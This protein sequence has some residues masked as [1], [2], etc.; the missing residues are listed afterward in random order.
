MTGD[1][2]HLLVLVLWLAVLG[3]L[4]ARAWRGQ[5]PVAGLAIA[6]WFQLWLIHWIGGAVYVLSNYSSQDRTVALIGFTVTG[7]AVAGLL[8]GNVLL[9][10]FLFRSQPAGQQSFR[11]IDSSGPGFMYVIIGLGLYFVTSR[12]L[13]RISGTDAIISSGFRLAIAGFCLWWLA[14]WQAGQKRRAWIVLASAAVVPFF[15]VSLDG[16]MG[17]GVIFLMCLAC[18]VAV[19]YRPRWH[20]LV[21]APAAL[22]VGI[23]LY[24]AYLSV[25]SNIRHAVWGGASYGERLEK[26][27]LIAGEYQWFDPDNPA[28]LRAIDMRL[29]QNILV[30]HSVNHLESGAVEYGEGE[31]LWNAMIALIPRAIWPGKPQYAGSGP[32]VTRFTGIKFAGET[33]V[34]IGQVMELYVNFGDLGV[35]IGFTVLGLLLGFF[36]LQAGMALRTGQ[37]KQ[38][39]FWFVVGLSFLQVGGNFAEATSSAAGSAMLCLLV[40]SFLGRDKVTMVKRP[41]L[42]SAKDGQA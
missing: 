42:V 30:G 4:V 27:A 13:P 29:N 21:V 25:R 31:T 26:M 39:A 40:N 33:S 24:P 5:Q 38:F 8:I 23:S 14:R 20:M 15:T 3:L 2:A 16:F 9:A 18:F 12:V 36:D 6:C 22:L 10:P 11:P 19:F 37:W 7:Y 34:G 28:H 1:S 41:V 17:Y 32:L 35:F